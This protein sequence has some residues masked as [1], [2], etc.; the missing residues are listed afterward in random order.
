MGGGADC[1]PLGECNSCSEHSS[2]LFDNSNRTHL[3]ESDENS[4]PPKGEIL[5]NLASWFERQSV[6][7]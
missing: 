4:L 6:D 5:E 7:A 1:S 2:T 3:N